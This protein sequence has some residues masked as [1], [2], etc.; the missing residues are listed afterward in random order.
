MVDHLVIANTGTGEE[1]RTAGQRYLYRS[2]YES[3]DRC[4]GFCAGFRSWLCACRRRRGD[5]AAGVFCGRRCPHQEAASD[6]DRGGGW[7][8]Q[9]DKYCGVSQNFINCWLT[10][11]L[12]AFG[13]GKWDGFAG[14]VVLD[15]RFLYATEEGGH[16]LSTEKFTSQRRC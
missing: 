1:K 7:C 8:Q 11:G 12:G 9:C 14:G 3:A 16:S 13:V 4:G 6:C 15:I 10:A 2:R 5:G